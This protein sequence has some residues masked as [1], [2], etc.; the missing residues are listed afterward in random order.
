[1]FKDLNRFYLDN[2][3]LWRLTTSWDGFQWLV[4]DDNTQNVIIFRRTNDEGEDVIAICNFAPVERDDYRF[5]IPEEKN[6][7]IAFSSDDIRYGGK[8]I[9]E[10]EIILSEKIAM[11]GK[12]NSIA[13]DIPPMS[14]MY[15]KPSSIQ[16]EP[17]VLRW[18]AARRKPKQNPLPNSQNQRPPAKKP[19]PQRPKTTRKKAT[20]EET[21]QEKPKDHPQKN[22]CSQGKDRGKAKADP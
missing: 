3:P 18:K 10:K 16:P 15:L 14:V 6:Y 4:H 21:A 7:E 13:V 12:S 1:M 5:G 22:G 17:K 8:G 20:S 11:H 19:P 2:S 9:P